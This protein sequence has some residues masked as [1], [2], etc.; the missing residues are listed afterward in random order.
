MSEYECP[1][2]RATVAWFSA[3]YHLR[4]W[5][6]LEATGTP[7]GEPHHTEDGT[8]CGPWCSPPEKASEA[9]ADKP[10]PEYCGGI[11]GKPNWRMQNGG[12]WHPWELSCEEFPECHHCPG[13]SNC[14]LGLLP[15]AKPPEEVPVNCPEGHKTVCNGN[16]A[17][18][19]M[20]E[21]NCWYGP[22]KP[23]RAEAI[24]MWNGVMLGLKGKP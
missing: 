22:T 24:R 13:C 5:T 12:G 16:V 19:V 2:G 1:A 21:P 9:P 6:T 8:I 14:V 23:T 20:C 15:K 18:Y 11:L 17:F 10:V 3:P 4:S 7:P